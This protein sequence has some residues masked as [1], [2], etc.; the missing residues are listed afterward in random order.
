MQHAMHHAL[1]DTLG[2]DISSNMDLQLNLNL[3]HMGG[4]IP[5][6]QFSDP[7]YFKNNI[8]SSK[9]SIFTMG[10]LQ[11]MVT[12]QAYLQVKFSLDGN[13][14]VQTPADVEKGISSTRE[15][16]DDGMVQTIVHI[17]SGVT[18]TRTFK[19]L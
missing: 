13:K 14:L 5:E 17:P 3:L 10:A 11:N 8:I 1:Q 18:A 9:G 12:L 16:S 19:R 7:K 15:F 6:K 4:P 2:P